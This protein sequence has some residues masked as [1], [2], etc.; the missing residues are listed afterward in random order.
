MGRSKA[1]SIKAWLPRYNFWATFKSETFSAVTQ[2]SWW[3][4]RFSHATRG[5][6]FLHILPTP[7]FD[8]SLFSRKDET[9]ANLLS[10]Y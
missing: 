8:V 6:S 4:N 2:Q 7:L 9:I 5:K 3:T 10:K 1:L